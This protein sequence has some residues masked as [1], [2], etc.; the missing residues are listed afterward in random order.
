MLEEE[1]DDPTTVLQMLLRVP[2]GWSFSLKTSKNE[3]C[4]LPWAV[5]LSKPVSHLLL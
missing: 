1:A 5:L 2:F 3:A 4:Q